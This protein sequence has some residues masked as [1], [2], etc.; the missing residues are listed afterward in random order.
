MFCKLIGALSQVSVLHQIVTITNY[1]CKLFQAT[2]RA[3]RQMSTPYQ[4]VLV[5]IDN[6]SYTSLKNYNDKVLVEKM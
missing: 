6:I 4:I 5:K 1:F 2:T 3:P